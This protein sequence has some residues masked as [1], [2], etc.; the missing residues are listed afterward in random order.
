MVQWVCDRDAEGKCNYCHIPGGWSSALQ[1]F[2]S[3]NLIVLC[4]SYY[5]ERQKQERK[6]SAVAGIPVYPG[7][8]LF[9]VDMEQSLK[10]T[11]VLFY[12]S[13]FPRA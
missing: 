3:D 6:F 9:P 11:M 8:F 2:C 7:S 13:S 5:L 12:T 4:G 1:K 10:E